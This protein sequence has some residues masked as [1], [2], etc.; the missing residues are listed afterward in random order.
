MTPKTSVTSRL[1][2]FHIDDGPLIGVETAVPVR[3]SG[4]VTS[5]LLLPEDD[6]STG[7]IYDACDYL[8]GSPARSEL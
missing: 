8:L 4:L 2:S 5:C 6:S 3:L 7:N 1:H